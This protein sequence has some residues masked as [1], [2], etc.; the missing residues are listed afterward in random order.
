MNTI[1]IPVDRIRVDRHQN[2]RQK[3]YEDNAEKWNE[4][5]AQIKERGIIVPVIVGK[6]D[7]DGNYP[8]IDGFRRMGVTAELVKEGAAIKAVPACIRDGNDAETLVD[9]LIC[10]DGVPFDPLEQ[11]AVIYK[12]R[13][14]KWP[15]EEIAQKTGRSAQWVKRTRDLLD[16]HPEVIQA[17]KD[18]QIAASEVRRIQTKV[19]GDKQI[20][21]AVVDEAIAETVK[22]GGNKATKAASD[23]AIVQLQASG[24]IPPV[25]TPASR[26]RKPMTA[27]AK[28]AAAARKAKLEAAKKSPRNADLI[29][30]FAD[31]TDFLNSADRKEK[32]R[33]HGL[34]EFVGT[35]WRIRYA[36]FKHEEEEEG[37]AE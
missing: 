33:V 7:A 5:K 26:G 37:K 4:L 29:Q 11:A 30:F 13:S 17:I 9:R 28:A 18:G 14:Y 21:A 36:P 6:P 2:I 24:A 19:G 34:L 10:G 31:C 15:D 23:L 16:H 20:T 8:L 32:A 1:E 3:N 12:L 35:S 22:K 25:V 27:K